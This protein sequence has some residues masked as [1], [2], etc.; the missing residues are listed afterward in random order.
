MD[1]ISIV[2]TPPGP[3]PT[4]AT[5]GETDGAAFK[6]ALETAA[7][8]EAPVANRA[9]PTAADAEVGD[10]ELT[11]MALLMALTAPV[12]AAAISAQAT[13]E[14]QPAP[15]VTIL[16]PV[17]KP[18]IAKADRAMPQP[19]PA[20]PAAPQADSAFA[21]GPEGPL[22]EAVDLKPSQTLRTP[23]RAMTPATTGEAALMAG[24]PAAA[25]QAST[26]NLAPATAPGPKSTAN[27]AVERPA[28]AWSEA[29]APAAPPA[30]PATVEARG[31]PTYAPPIAVAEPARLAE[32]RP[33]EVLTQIQHAVE[34]MGE[35][36]LDTVR[37]QLN[38]EH[39]GRI[40]LQ[41]SH[42]SDGALNVQV[43]AEQPQTVALLERH[44]TELRTT[45]SA[46]QLDVRHVAVSAG[47]TG[48]RRQQQP[49]HGRPAKIAIR[50]LQRAELDAAATAAAT[51]PLIS[52][53][54][55]SR[56]ALAGV[57]Y[58]I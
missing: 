58:R 45:L 40:E 23:T 19:V 5:S 48:D 55:T 10:V 35:T 18:T 3:V 30:H 15:D 56:L 25:P 32:A 11:K 14:T 27:V 31:I 43:R 24:P 13:T 1:P 22:A 36:Q 38:P 16:V 8:E 7:A 54:P 20:R 26:P 4:P 44:L 39:L 53:Y 49:F 47:T 33:T 12:T 37:I 21:A 46:N 28:A 52:V 17:K 2:P 42:A 29:P 51:G 9:I 50:G 34:R 41:V 6:Q 57:D